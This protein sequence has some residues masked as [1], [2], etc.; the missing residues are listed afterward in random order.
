MWTW[1]ELPALS[2]ERYDLLLA[3]LDRFLPNTKSHYRI[4]YN[5]FEFVH[6][7][8]NRWVYMNFT[9]HV[10]PTD[11]C[12][13]FEE[14]GYIIKRTGFN[15]DLLRFPEEARNYPPY[16]AY[17]A[18]KL[19]ISLHVPTIRM[20]RRYRTTLPERTQPIHLA[21]QR[22]FEADLDSFVREHST[23]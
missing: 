21:A 12:R 2:K 7:A 17:A 1:S 3:F 13:A 22:Q 14:K 5:E 8:I 15:D 4:R 6:D 20:L 9:F 10:P 11:L 19:H 18:A 16:E 23:E